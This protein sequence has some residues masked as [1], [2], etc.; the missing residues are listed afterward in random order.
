MR[1]RTLL[2]SLTLT[3]GITGVF[4]NAAADTLALRQNLAGNSPGEYSE[5]TVFLTE[6]D[7]DRTSL[8]EKL[9]TTLAEDLSK[10]PGLLTHFEEVI[11]SGDRTPSSTNPADDAVREIADGRKVVKRPLTK[12]VSIALRE[13]FPKWVFKNNRVIFSIARGSIN[14]TVTT[15]S[16]MA[17]QH[18]PFEIALASGVITGALSGG[19]QYMNAGLQKFLTTSLAE[20]FVRS[21]GLKKGTKFVESL[22]RWYT[23]E[24]GFIGVIQV[25]LAAMGHPPAGTLVQAV[26]VNLSSALKAVAAQGLWDI[27]V[28]KATN[29]SMNLAKTANAKNIIR[30][31]SDLVTLGLSA[32]SVAGMVG[33]LAGLPFGDTVFIAM[34]GTG[35]LVLAK[36][37]YNEWRCRKNFKRPTEASTSDRLSGSGSSQGN[38]D[39]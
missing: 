34:G 2:L 37:I 10:N 36:V 1:L 32:L 27:A 28:S 39:N 26:G 21:E 16:L 5:I 38:D 31:R 3:L 30:F 18:L 23:L 13:K 24:V 33:Q 11:E 6:T 22:F 9:R 29:R 14:S 17:T 35:A 4:R 15:W 25:T 7:E 20:K 8:I 19:L 12:E